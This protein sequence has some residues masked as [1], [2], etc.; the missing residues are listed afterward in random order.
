MRWLLLLGAQA[1]YDTLGAAVDALG[2]LGEVHE[3]AAERLTGSAGGEPGQYRNRLVSL[4]HAGPREALVAE[5]KRIER[6]LG[7]GRL[8]GMPVD[9]DLL[10]CAH[11]NDWQPDPHAVAKREF[12]MPHVRL[13]LA[14]AGLEA[15]LPA[16]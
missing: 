16:A 14:D 3:H 9:I 4:R 11:G 13:L 1:R 8:D 2:A 6:D 7:R 15:A 5:C 10:A 12:V